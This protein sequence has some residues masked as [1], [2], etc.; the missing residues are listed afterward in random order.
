MILKFRDS[1][2]KLS[3]GEMYVVPKG[4]EHKPSAKKECKILVVE[5]R[6]VINTGD[7]GGRLTINEEMWI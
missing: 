3:A 1:E 2:V 4:V 7:T 6:G 5:P